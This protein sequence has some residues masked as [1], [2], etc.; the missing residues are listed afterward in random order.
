MKITGTDGEFNG[1]FKENE[2][3]KVDANALLRLVNSFKSGQ[4]HRVLE[5]WALRNHEGSEIDILTNNIKTHAGLVDKVEMPAQYSDQVPLSIRVGD[6]IEKSGDYDRPIDSF[7]PLPGKPGF[8]LKVVVLGSNT[9]TQ[10]VYVGVQVADRKFQAW[11]IHPDQ[12]KDVRVCGDSS[13]NEV[14]TLLPYVKE[15]IEVA[16]RNKV[17]NFV[18]GEIVKREQ[19]GFYTD[20]AAEVTY[21]AVISGVSKDGSEVIYSHP[22]GNV[23]FWR[24]DISC[25]GTVESTGRHLSPEA[26]EYLLTCVKDYKA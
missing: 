10:D 1:A 4:T 3:M 17:G 21:E 16:E 19:G 13:D 11:T 2:M 5:H 9:E 8:V 25:L 6:W 23:R 22:Q 7:F 26:L 14:N 18:L 24:E 12:L 20:R 15:L